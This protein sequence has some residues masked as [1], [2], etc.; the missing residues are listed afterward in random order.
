MDQVH[1][2]R[3]KVLV[4][5]RSSR[6][7]AQGMGLSRNTVR[8]YLTRA[9]PVRV[10]SAPRPRPVFER[11]HA[12]L[13]AL[14]ADSPR[15]MGGKQRLTATQA[16]RMLLAEGFSVGQ[17]LVKEVVAEWRRKRREVF[18]PLVYV[19]TLFGERG[20]S[21]ARGAKAMPRSDEGTRAGQ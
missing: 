1:V 10:E 20:V 5:G 18:V 3:H 2:V 15:W 21:I 16:H 17:T 7:V 6:H 12:R 11:V 13:E 4:E 9:A 19:E 14:L 8:R